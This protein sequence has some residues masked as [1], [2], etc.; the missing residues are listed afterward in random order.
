VFQPPITA[1]DFVIEVN[2]DGETTVVDGGPVL[3]DP[4]GVVYEANGTLSDTIP[5]VQVTCY[6]SDTHSG[7]WL[8]WDAWTYD[9]VN[10]Q[11]TL[12]DGYYSFYTPPGTYRVTAEKEGYPLYTSPDLVVVDRPVRHNIPLESHKVYLPVVMRE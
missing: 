11:V 3:I 7:Q 1:G 10:P 4:D 9:Q 12:D 8:T 5:G 2:A 6:Y